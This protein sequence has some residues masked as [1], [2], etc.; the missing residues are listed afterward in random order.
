M[1]V[2]TPLVRNEKVSNND[3]DDGAKD[4]IYKSMMMVCIFQLLDKN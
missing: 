1:L 4:F 2:A 3:D